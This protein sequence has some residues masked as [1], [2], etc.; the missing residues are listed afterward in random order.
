MYT[1]QFGLF[2]VTCLMVA[3]KPLVGNIHHMSLSKLSPGFTSD[4]RPFYQDFFLLKR[5][6]F[7]NEFNIRHILNPAKTVP[8]F[9]PGKK[10][11]SYTAERFPT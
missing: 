6:L 4:W 3:N 7:R 8:M 9:S 11:R 2:A 1:A 5:A 10:R